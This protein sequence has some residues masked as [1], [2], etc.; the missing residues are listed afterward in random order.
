[1]ELSRQLHEACTDHPD[2]PPDPDG[3]PPAARL[4]ITLAMLASGYYP[5]LQQEAR[6][7]LLQRIYGADNVRVVDGEADEMA[8][9]APWTCPR[10]GLVSLQA[11]TALQLT[12]V[13]CYHQRPRA[14]EE[15]RLEALQTR[16]ADCGA[17]VTLPAGALDHRCPFCA[18]VIWRMVRT[19]QAERD[20][21]REIMRQH[22]GEPG[23]G[24]EGLPLSESNRRQLVIAGLGRQ[25]CYYWRYLSPWR[26]LELARAS[27]P[28]E[29]A[30]RPALEE[31][32]RS[33]RDEGCEPGGLELI[34]A[35]M[36]LG[37]TGR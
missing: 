11:R 3:M 10:C 9:F 18:A 17:E 37:M 24:Q 28:D 8:L 30:L 21:A 1:M 36:E 27:L 20:Y 15:E 22:G 13:A 4:R 5:T 23:P 33:A 34:R 19:W 31:A 26:L 2:R 14:E 6:G 29:P 16:C 25:A 7:A 32:L 35:A 12:C